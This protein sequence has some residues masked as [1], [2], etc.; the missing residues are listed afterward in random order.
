VFTSNS[1]LDN[2]VEDRKMLTK[3]VDGNL[4]CGIVSA[5]MELQISEVTGCLTPGQNEGL[6]SS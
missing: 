6:D 3:I 1:S 5:A 4:D 2:D